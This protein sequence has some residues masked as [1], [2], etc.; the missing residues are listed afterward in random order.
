MPEKLPTEA[1]VFVSDASKVTSVKEL[2]GKTIAT[3]IGS[4]HHRIM[5]VIAAMR[6]NP[7]RKIKGVI[8]H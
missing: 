2:D 7:H 3:A 1:A 4:S 6:G 5:D 8:I